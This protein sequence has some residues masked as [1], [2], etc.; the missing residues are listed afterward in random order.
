[1]NP[2]VPRDA[3]RSFLERAEDDG[4]I[5]SYKW[6]SADTWVQLREKLGG[7][8][9]AG[10]SRTHKKGTDGV[11]WAV[12]V[13]SHEGTSVGV[14]LEM[15]IE[16][17]VLD[18]PDWILRRLGMSKGASPKNIIEE[19]SLRESAFKALAPDNARVTL[20]QL[21]HTSPNTLSLL[22]QTGE[23][24]IQVRSMWSGKWCLTL[25][26]RTVTV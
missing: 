26:W 1:M 22:T 9:V 10:V 12:E 25:G 23:K 7:A 6:V 2:A 17:P 20:S 21:R 13:E 24:S 16:R 18:R 19:W 15:L 8:A 14:D 3:F 4:W 5:A 11:W